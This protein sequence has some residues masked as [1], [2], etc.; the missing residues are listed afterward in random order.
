MAALRAR[1]H[2]EDKPFA[3]MVADLAGARALCRVDPAEEAMLA[4]PRRPI[5]LLRRRPEGPGRRWRRRWRR[6]TGRWG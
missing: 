2:R 3:V 1:K 5:V 4:S 6:G